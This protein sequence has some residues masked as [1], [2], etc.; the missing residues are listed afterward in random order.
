M[1]TF[2]KKKK[3]KTTGW[4][5]FI[6]RLQSFMI[7][8]TKARNAVFFFSRSFTKCR[9]GVVFYVLHECERINESFFFIGGVEISTKPS[10]NLLLTLPADLSL[11]PSLLTLYFPSTN[12]RPP[13]HNF[14]SPS[15]NTLTFSM[16]DF[17]PAPPSSASVDDTLLFP[18]FLNREPYKDLF[19][20]WGFLQSGEWSLHAYRYSLVQQNALKTEVNS[21]ASADARFNAPSANTDFSSKAVP[22]PSSTVTAAAL[23]FHHGMAKDFLLSLFSSSA[24][25]AQFSS[26]EPDAGSSLEFR[27]LTCH[28]STLEPLRQALVDANVVRQVCPC[29]D[30]SE[31]VRDALNCEGD[32]RLPTVKRAEELLPHGEVIGDELRALFLLAH[33]RRCNDVGRWEH[34]ARGKAKAV[35][36]SDGEASDFGDADDDDD[37]WSVMAGGK[38]PLRQLRSVFDRKARGEFLYHVLWRL[39]AGGGPLNQF[40]DDAAVYMDVTRQLYRALITSFRVREAASTIAKENMTAL[41][42]TRE[43]A[44]A[45]RYEAVVETLVYEVVAAPGMR[46][47]PASDGVVPSNLNY[48]YV[49]VNP[50]EQAVCIWYHHC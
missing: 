16:F 38:L 36:E 19:T 12:E 9:S 25:Q 50:S 41:A 2:K 24:V 26:A 1:C 11:A 34:G 39:I 32:A 21:A 27:P 5:I 22:S 47:F 17:R 7:A 40:E 45:T 10:L 48:C 44:G 46:L 4:F 14:A 37:M 35:S 42:S 20:K 43:P 30:D 13:R 23:R 49:V 29:S 3:R 33:S 6:F 31:S 18:P 15:V 8:R 28:W